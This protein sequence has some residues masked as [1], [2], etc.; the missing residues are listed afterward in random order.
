[1]IKWTKFYDSTTHEVVTYYNDQKTAHETHQTFDYATPEETLAK[2][3]V[4]TFNFWD[5]E[6]IGAGLLAA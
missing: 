6:P 3:T 5:N 4:E 2:S 1:M